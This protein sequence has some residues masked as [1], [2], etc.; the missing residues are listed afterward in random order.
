MKRSITTITILVFL[1]SMSFAQKPTNIWTFGKNAG[2]DFNSGS[3]VIM[4]GSSLYNIEG[5]TSI[6][7]NNGNLLFYT[8]GDTVWNKNHVMMPNGFGLFGHTSSTQSALIVPAPGN[9]NI[10]YVFTTGAQAGFIGG[11]SGIAYSVVDMS[12]QAGLGDVTI[13]NTLLLPN[14]CEKL[15]AVQ[16]CNG[17]DFWVFGHEFGTNAFYAFPVT[18]TGV[19]APVITNI[20]PIMTTGFGNANCLG[21][22][23]ASQNGRKLVNVTYAFQVQSCILDLDPSTGILSN[24]V[25]IP[26]NGYGVEFSP[27]GTKVYFAAQKITTTNWRIYQYDL[28]AS[29]ILASEIVISN[30]PFADV[31]SLQLGP[32]DKIYV[33]R[34][35]SFGQNPFL[36]VINNPDVAGTG[37]NY[38]DNAINFLPAEST[39]GLPGF[40]TSYFYREPK[41][42]W[43]TTCPYDTARFSI[44]CT[45][46]QIDSVRWNFADPSTGINNTS[47]LQNPGHVFS[48]PGTYSVQ[49]LIHFECRT[50]TVINQVTISPGASVTLSPDVSICAG[51]STPLSA[52]GTGTFQWFPPTGLNVSTGPNVVSTPQNTITY[53]VVATDSGCVDTAYVTVTVLPAPTTSIAGNTTLCSG[54][55][56]S[57]TASGAASYTWSTGATTS[58]L[59]VIP[60]ST[61]TYTVTGSNGI[62]TASSSVTVTVNQTPVASISGDTTICTGTNSILTAGGGGTYTWS[63]GATTSSIFVSPNVNTT[64]SVI[65]A[66]GSCADTAIVNVIALASPTADA[67]PDV[68]ISIS[69]AAQLSASGGGSYIWSPSTGLSCTT[70]P[71]PTANPTSTTT[72]YL[73]VTSPN[74][75][76]DVDTINVIVTNSCDAS[77]GDVFVADAFSPNGDGVNDVLHVKGGGMKTIYFAVYDRWGAK[78]FES[79]DQNTGWDGLYKNGE[80]NPGVY[81]Y[82]LKAECYLGGEFFFKG[83]ITL[84]R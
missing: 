69:S 11:Y 71:N 13:K 28:C 5:C 64:Y 49:T 35:N 26:M 36:A 22:M 79:T 70:C 14:A 2:L 57:L 74:G 3:P 34:W 4:T 37:C 52:S 12:L 81:V 53:M 56:T 19:G 6:A 9:P 62:C 18:S 58:V 68:T 76:T 21:Q 43:T 16:Q 31:Q 24:P 39:F 41:I 7:D 61:T 78:V 48:A 77:E 66:N 25:N 47:L 73:T 54:D 44:A 82:I 10:Y 60:T 65:V 50:D 51:D 55:G 17:T 27:D 20:G 32:D 83:N 23:K 45:T 40:V 80:L 1:V 46:D 42:S 63:T 8:Y 72:Y 15:T 33:A 75:C 29:N 84:L 67:G 38:V 59:N 30:N